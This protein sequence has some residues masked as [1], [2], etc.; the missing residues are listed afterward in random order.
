MP[1]KRL[2]E[3]QL[4]I[5]SNLPA[6]S[7]LTLWRQLLPYGYTSASCATP[8]KA[9]IFNLCHPGTLTLSP[10]RQSAQMSKIKKDGL[11]HAVWYSNSAIN[12]LFLH[13]LMELVTSN[14]S[15]NPKQNSVSI[16]GTSNQLDSKCL[17]STA[18]EP[19]RLPAQGFIQELTWGV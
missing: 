12:H 7:F 13:V 5:T 2:D 9:V 18:S 15:A 8:N 4:I 11:T 17:L 14:T 10:E 6:R 3:E 16:C 19:H 1:G